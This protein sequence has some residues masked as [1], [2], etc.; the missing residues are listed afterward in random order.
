MSNE[1]L[2]YK[3]YLTILGLETSNLNIVELQRLASLKIISGGMGGAISVD[4][5][6]FFDNTTARDNYFASNPSEL[7]EGLYCVVAEQLQQ[8]KTDTWVGVSTIVKVGAIKDNITSSVEIGALSAGDVIESGL[9]LDAVMKRLL[10]K[11]FNPTFVNP[12]YVLSSNPSGQVES[13]SILNITLTGSLN[14]GRING[15]IVSGAWDSG[16]LQD[17]RAGA[18]TKYI[19][20]GVDNGLVNTKTLNSTQVVDGANSWNSTV[21]FLQGVQPKNSI[22]ENFDS[23]HPAGSLGSSVTLQ[24]RRKL[25][26]GSDTTNNIAYTSSGEVRALSNDLL[27]PSNGTTF[28]ISVPVGAKMVTFAYPNSLR[29]VTSIRYVEG[30][31]A[32]VKD[33]FTKT[34]LNVEGANGYNAIGYKLYTFIPA[35]SFSSTATYNIT[36]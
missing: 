27:N 20:D 34:L 35:E 8:Y 9:D 14:R 31:N 26:F 6:H 16:A 22:N 33:I 36:I 2:L 4:D 3:Q 29:D 13:G 17:F 30:L 7:E 25:F 11:T 1:E 23:P 21:Q 5:N 19:F 18:P 28:T 15:K 12:S 10:L 32:E 24:G